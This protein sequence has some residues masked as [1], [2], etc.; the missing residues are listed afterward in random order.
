MIQILELSG[1]DFKI[2]IINMFQKIEENIDKMNGKIKVTRE[3]DILYS[4]ASN[5]HSRSEN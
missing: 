1:K 4:K 3:M 5:R 2:T